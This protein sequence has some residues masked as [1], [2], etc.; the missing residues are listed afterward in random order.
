MSNSKPIFN[1]HLTYEE[2]LENAKAFQSTHKADDGKEL[3]IWED[4][5]GFYNESITFSTDGIFPKTFDDDI[6]EGFEIGN[7]DKEARAALIWLIGWYNDGFLNRLQL[8]QVIVGVQSS[9]FEG[10][11]EVAI[12]T[13]LSKADDC[14]RDFIR[15][16][17]YRLTNGK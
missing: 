6:R 13:Y 14:L 9:G 15:E 7:V 4:P 16:K 3:Y 17:A 10:D 2:A 1:L 11:R 12:F 5:K 8:G